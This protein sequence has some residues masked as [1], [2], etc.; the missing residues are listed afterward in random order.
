MIILGEH[1]GNSLKSENDRYAL[2]DENRKVCKDIYFKGELAKE[3]NHQKDTFCYKLNRSEGGIYQFETSY[4]IGVDWIGDTKVPIYVEPKINKEQKEIDYL[5]ML[6]EALQEPQNFNHLHDL[7]TIDF[8]APLIEINQ[9]QDKL[10][11]LLLL[12]FLQLVKQI[13][14]KGLKKSYYK[15]TKNLNARVKGKI[16]INN[17]I[18]QNHSK[19]KP[20]YNICQFEEFGYNSIENKILKKALLFAQSTLRNFKYHSEINL[21]ELFYY[22]SPA[23][24]NI[25]DQLDIR[26]LKN[27]KPNPLFKEYTQALKLAEIILRKYGYNISKTAEIKIKTPP[28]W[29][30]MTKLFELYILKKLRTIFP[31][32]NEIIYQKKTHGLALDYL[33][34]VSAPKTQM[35]IDAKYKP[36]YEGGNISLDD[37]R[38]VAGYARL[39]SI[40]S[41]LG[42]QGEERNK[43]IDCLIIYSNQSANDLELNFDNKIEDYKYLN[44]FK[45]GVKLPEI[46]L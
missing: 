21:Q 28:F 2:N 27:N 35:I 39:K 20:H 45:I 33:L 25:D 12:E 46:I 16:L 36:N 5:S 3:F 32:K 8:N 30:D 19:Q 17:S 23:F 15:V 18:K 4:Y 6:F 26:A 40:Y 29:I 7:Y 31:N 34:N 22:V 10:T 13:V 14:R 38:Q 1:F 24:Q 11:P 37:A 43:M 9:Q 41:A 44:L 42:I